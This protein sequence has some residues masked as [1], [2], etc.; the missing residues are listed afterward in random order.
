MFKVE[1][2]AE[3]D[4]LLG[5]QQEEGEAKSTSLSFKDTSAYVSVA[6]TWSNNHIKLQGNLGVYFSA[7]YTQL[8]FRVLVVFVK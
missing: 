4:Y 8:K 3:H 5:Q 1:P 2:C 7:K 6:I